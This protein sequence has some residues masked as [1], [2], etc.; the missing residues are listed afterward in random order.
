MGEVKKQK[1]IPSEVVHYPKYRYQ[2]DYFNHLKENNFFSLNQLT[3][4]V[5]KRAIS[6]MYST[7]EWWMEKYIQDV[8]D[9][10]SEFGIHK[11]INKNKK[12]NL[13]YGISKLSL[14]NKRFRNEP[15]YLEAYILDNL[16]EFKADGTI[17]RHYKVFYE[18]DFRT[19]EWD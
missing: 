16:Q 1:L 2:P 13:I 17:I 15:K 3:G 7:Q 9:Y 10:I 18:P 8:K 12:H 4:E 14:L 19:I 5:R 6:Q 11:F